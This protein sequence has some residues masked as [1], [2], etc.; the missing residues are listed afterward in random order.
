MN[1]KHDDHWLTRPGTIKLLWIA[2]IAILALTV[3]AQ[4]FI[5]IKG[6]F[7][8]DEWFGFGAVYGFVSCLI[9]VLVAK[10]LGF[11]LKRKESYYTDKKR[12]GDEN[13]P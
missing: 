3:A 1:Q 5:K 12:Q 9:M 8:P 13:G 6:Y 7:G 4:L 2:F 11:V 10:V